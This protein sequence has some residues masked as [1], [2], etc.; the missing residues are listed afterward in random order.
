M[1]YHNTRDAINNKEIILVKVKSSE[2]VADLFT[3]PLSAD[4]IRSLIKDLFDL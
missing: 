1:S 4:R 2:N 3:K